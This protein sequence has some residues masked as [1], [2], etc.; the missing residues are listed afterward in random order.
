MG[1]KLT[2]ELWMDDRLTEWMTSWGGGELRKNDRLT[3][4]VTS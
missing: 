1:D 3:E 2:V 4:W